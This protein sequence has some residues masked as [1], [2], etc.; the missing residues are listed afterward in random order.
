[1]LAIFAQSTIAPPAGFNDWLAS[2]FYLVG[3]VTAAVVLYKHL[4]GRP[5][6]TEIAG[7]PLT[8]QGATLFT[9]IEAHNELKGRVDG[10]SRDIAA[11]F[12]RLDHKR[13]VSVAGLHDDLEVA[14]ENLRKEV[15][16]DV[17]GV[18]DRIN[19]VLAAVSELRGKVG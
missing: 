14:I 19:A 2:A 8:I 10:I 17:K 11:G 6:S 9:P 18:H 7:Q 13:S 12:E 3:L 4:H 5:T 1:M 16:E 15:K